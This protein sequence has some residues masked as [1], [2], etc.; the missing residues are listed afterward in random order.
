MCQSEAACTQR[1][2]RTQGW[3]IE[4]VC[5]LLLGFSPSPTHTHA[6][7]MHRALFLPTD[8]SLWNWGTTPH[9]PCFLGVEQPCRLL[10]GSS[11]DRV[12]P[13]RAER[14]IARGV[15]FR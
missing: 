9:A 2:G 5:M 12:T 3:H 1:R 14:L 7:D 8:C 6:E 15:I 13:T 4:G 10:T 11:P